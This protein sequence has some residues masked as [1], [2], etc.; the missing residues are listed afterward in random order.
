M[1]YQIYATTELQ[2]KIEEE[3]EVTGLSASSIIT[4][5]LEMAFGLKTSNEDVIFSEALEKICKEVKE[6]VRNFKENPKDMK[7]DFTLYDAS[8]TF[9]GISTTESNKQISSLRARLGKAFRRIYDSGKIN[10]ITPYKVDGLQKRRHNAAIYLIN[11][12]E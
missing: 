2:K 6:Y 7:R 11:E 9:N 8:K 3:M 1:R 5:K 4:E 12:E 10:G